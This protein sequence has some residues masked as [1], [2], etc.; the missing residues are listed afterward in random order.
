MILFWASRFFLA[1]L[2]LLKVTQSTDDPHCLNAM[3]QNIFLYCMAAICDNTASANRMS[4]F[5]ILKC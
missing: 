4:F 1:M 3:K 5:E 2:T